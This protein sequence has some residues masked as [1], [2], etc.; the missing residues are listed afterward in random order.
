MASLEYRV[1]VHPPIP[2][3]EQEMYLKE[4]SHICNPA[5]LPTAF[6][7]LSGSDASTH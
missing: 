7:F 3:N 2:Q 6:R 1:H 5:A 4:A